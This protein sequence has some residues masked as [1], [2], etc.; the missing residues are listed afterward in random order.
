MSKA[1]QGFKDLLAETVR[2]V[3]G[4]VGKGMESEEFQEGF[5]ELNQRMFDRFHR[6]INSIGVI[7]GLE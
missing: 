6:T 1:D 2:L 3:G 4:A 5:S 7:L